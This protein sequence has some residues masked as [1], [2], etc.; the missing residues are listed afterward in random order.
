MRRLGDR[1]VLCMWGG[2][3]GGGGWL[4]RE[5]S[6]GSHVNLQ[7]TREKGGKLVSKFLQSKDL[8]LYDQAYD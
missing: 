3:G 7:T 6:S 5:G 4:M 2:G 8:L 1:V